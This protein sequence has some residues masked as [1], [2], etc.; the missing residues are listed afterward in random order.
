MS[1]SVRVCADDDEGDDNYNSETFYWML[2]WWMV[3]PETVISLI[4]RK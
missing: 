4:P 2:R 1:S 3:N